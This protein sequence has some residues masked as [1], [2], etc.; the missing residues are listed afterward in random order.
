MSNG[1][2][3]LLPLTLCAALAMTACGSVDKDWASASAQNTVAGY[4]AFLDRHA[5]DQHAQDARTR[6]AAL[7]DDSAWI[8]AQN[9]NSLGSY[10]QY[11]QAEPNGTHAQ[12][13]L[14]QITGLER[15]STWKTA[16]SDGSAGAL[17]AFLQTYP[18]GPEAD[19]ARQKLAVLQTNY[20]AELG[21]F[22]DERAA[23]RRRS[24]LQTR[25]SSVLKE[26]DVVSPDS[27]NKRYRVMSGLMDRQDADS[28][29]ASLKR[30]HQSC[31]V[32]N[33]NQGRS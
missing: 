4:Q 26:L 11:L 24:E 25:F 27:S 7:Q 20:R 23:K 13:A 9:G 15:A 16:Q 31:E 21:R 12:A 2:K 5:S 28:T 18:Q 1:Y 3:Y 32:V 30:D 33:A 17:R 22:N 6:I 8:T 10:Q 19:Q 29:C 14:D